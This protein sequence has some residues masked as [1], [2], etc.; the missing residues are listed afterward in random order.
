MFENRILTVFVVTEFLF[1][2]TGGL[3]V[4]F[5][6]I[7]EGEMTATPTLENVAKELFLLECPLKGT[8]PIYL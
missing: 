1:L 4:A 6:L 2:L 3:L 8:P 5:A 7:S